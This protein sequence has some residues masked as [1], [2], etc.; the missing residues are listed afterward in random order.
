MKK[1]YKDMLS[2][3]KVIMPN[4]DAQDLLML[5]DDF[6]LLYSED[7]R[8]KVIDIIT[9]NKTYNDAHRQIIDLLDLCVFAA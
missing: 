4:Q 6:H 2:D 5:A 9:K 7:T 3:K 1:I 8:E